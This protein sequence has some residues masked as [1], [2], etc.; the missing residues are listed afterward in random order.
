M[1]VA[2]MIFGLMAA[3]CLADEND[4]NPDAMAMEDGAGGGNDAGSNNA[5]QDGGPAQPPD[6]Q[7]QG[8]NDAQESPD[9][10]S[11]S[12]LTAIDVTSPSATVNV[13][14]TMG[15]T[16]TGTF[17]DGS[18]QD[19]TTQAA[20]SS[21]RTSVASVSGDGVVSGIAAGT[22]TI[23]ASIGAIR[24]ATNVTVV[25]VTPPPPDA[26]MQSPDGPSPGRDAPVA[27]PDAWVPPPPDAGPVL[28]QPPLGPQTCGTGP[29]FALDF[30]TGNA[31]FSDARNPY[32]GQGGG[33]YVVGNPA[34]LEYQSGPM[35]GQV[36]SW[37]VCPT[38][39][40]VRAQRVNGWWLVPLPAL[41]NAGQNEVELQLR[42]D[43]CGMTD[44]WN[45][46]VGS[47]VQGQWAT[48]LEP[49]PGGPKVVV[50]VT[51]TGNT[52]TAYCGRCR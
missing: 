29:A 44:W 39:S 11:Q 41:V 23:T 43:R 7:T 28:P 18:T 37:Q 9:A 12:R 46:N 51:K 48:C 47:S 26:G 42:P 3:G 13:G 21:S 35:I 45:L 5:N 2:M 24:G 4:L 19:L 38:P 40:G 27:Q 49:S 22:T 10:A 16:A 8:G 14:A 36:P 15:L 34:A 25:S 20:W 52:A 17:S 32:C 1:I 6:A 33:T 50:C 31:W 30:A